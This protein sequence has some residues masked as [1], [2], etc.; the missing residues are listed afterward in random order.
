MRQVLRPRVSAPVAHYDGLYAIFVDKSLHLL[1]EVRSVEQDFDTVSFFNLLS[2]G[3]DF[4]ELTIFDK[5][6][7]AYLIEEV[8][9]VLGLLEVLGYCPQ[10]M[11]SNSAILATVEAE[12][13]TVT[14]ENT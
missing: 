3:L 2:E 10:K 8:L 12:S 1:F 9:F 13:N 7:E 4:W 11:E 14:D 5:V 6:H